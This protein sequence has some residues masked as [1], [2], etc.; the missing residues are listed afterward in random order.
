MRRWCGWGGA[1]G[2]RMFPM[3]ALMMVIFAGW[4]ARGAGTGRCCRGK[5]TDSFDDFKTYY[6]SFSDV[7]FSCHAGSDPTLLDGLRMVAFSNGRASAFG[8]RR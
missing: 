2:R 1:D 4:T 8:R 3:L 6:S 7:G 5:A